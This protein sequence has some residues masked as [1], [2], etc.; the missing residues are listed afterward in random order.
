MNSNYNFE[1]AKIDW[2]ELNKTEGDLVPIYMKDWYWDA[3][4][5]SG[6]E[7]KVICLYKNDKVEAAFPFLYTKRKGM[8]FIELPWQVACAGI[9]Y[10]DKELSNKERALLYL[11]DIVNQ[12]VEL[13]PKYDCFKINF[14]HSLWTWH[15]FYWL[16]FE[17]TPL[18]TSIIRTTDGEGWSQISQRRKRSIKKAEKKYRIGINEITP[19]EYWNFFEESY[20]K[21][22]RI[23]SYNKNKFLKLIQAAIE[24]NACEIRSVYYQETLAA[25]NILLKDSERSYD[26]FF[27]YMPGIGDDAQSFATYDGIKATLKE[28]LVFDFEGSMIPGVCEFYTSWNPVYES[29]YLIKK[30]SKKYNRLNAIRTFLK[31]EKT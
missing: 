11:N 6:D 9:W 20:K 28:G 25:V 24:N 12:V 27:S 21:R 26:Q 5:N 15:P 14:N 10:R 23:I 2:R 22:N 29:N 31:G 3:V 30:T 19:E 1:K 16:G 8:W 18:Y 13:L 17:A 7:W 4:C